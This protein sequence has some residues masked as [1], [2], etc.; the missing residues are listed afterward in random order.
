MRLTCP[1]CDAQYEVPDEV[2]PAQGRDVQCSACGCTWFQPH[3]DHPE[4]APPADPDGDDD[5]VGD[6]WDDEAD[7]HGAADDDLT[8]DDDLGDDWPDGDEPDTDDPEADRDPAPAAAPAKPAPR[9]VDPEVGDI[10]RQEAEREA[11]LRAA[12]AQALESQP[13]LGLDAHPGDDSDRRAREADA[14]KARMR[15]EPAKP[16]DPGTGGRR[17]VF[18]DIDEIN[19]SLRSTEAGTRTDLGPVRADPEPAPRRRGGFLRGFV[20]ALLLAAMLALIYTNAQQI[21]ETVPQ[22]DPM[23][24]AFVALV[25][26]G[27][28]WLDARVGHLMPE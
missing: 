22:A 7:I 28:V 21:A 20:V 18:P 3:P 1:N 14:R 27:R 2:M 11:Q 16:A 9:R 4:L 6:D 24:S 12:E 17:N 19:S 8:G 15:G 13:D 26:Q 5:L 25:D 23:L 10:L